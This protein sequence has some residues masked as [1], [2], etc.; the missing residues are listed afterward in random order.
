MKILAAITLSLMLAGCATMNQAE[1]A[2]TKTLV[3]AK[4]PVLKNYSKER[5][6]KAAAELE[7]LPS[8]SELTALLTD[9][10]KLRDACRAITK[11][12]KKK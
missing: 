9:Y 12:L 4:C 5:L 10:S 8:D 1:I 7:S 3:I 11:E 6:K 2:Q